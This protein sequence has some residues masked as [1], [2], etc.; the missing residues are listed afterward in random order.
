MIRKMVKIED[1]D[2]TRTYYV[3]GATAVRVVK[4]QVGSVKAE[5]E[6]LEN[7]WKNR[8]K[9]GSTNVLWLRSL[10]LHRKCPKCGRGFCD[11]MED[12]TNDC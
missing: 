5:V 7:T 9:Q 4:V 12:D 8:R 3:L 6:Y 11:C 2:L 1:L 10:W